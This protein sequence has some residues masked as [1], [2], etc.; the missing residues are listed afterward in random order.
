MLTCVYNI[1]ATTK[2]CGH[3]KLQGSLGN[4]IYLCAWE[5]EE[6]DIDQQLA[7]S[8]AITETKWNLSVLYWVGQ[9]VRSGFPNIFQKNLNELLGQTNI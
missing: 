1:L 7:V 3:T 8:P 4:V 2:S 9:K 6:L 5:K